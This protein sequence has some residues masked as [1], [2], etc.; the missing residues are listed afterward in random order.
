[1][2]AFCIT[3]IEYNNISIYKR[4]LGNLDWPEEISRFENLNL[5][6]FEIQTLWSQAT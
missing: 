2:I 4:W 6:S 1:M 5:N 3:F